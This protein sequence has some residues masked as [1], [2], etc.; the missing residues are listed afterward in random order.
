MPSSSGLWDGQGEL[1]FESGHC[2]RGNFQFG[3]RHGL[4]MFTWADGREY[5]GQFEHDQRHGQGKYTWKNNAD[6]NDDSFVVVYEGNFSHNQ[7]VGHG[8]YIDSVAQIE[9]VG[10][11]LAGVYEG[12]GVYNWLDPITGNKQTYRGCFVT[13]KPHGRGVQID[14]N[15][16]VVHDGEWKQGEPI[17]PIAE[18]GEGRGMST[19][20]PK[21]NLTTP[22]PATPDQLRQHQTPANAT[23][24]Q[25]YLTQYLY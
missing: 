13:G 11:W 8:K 6:V 4:G 7:R 17:Q 25:C 24:R 2:Y 20:D 22:T 3:H 19:P 15:G 10:E 16:V 21:S 18:T 1:L 14:H 9:Y 12:H 5:V 23:K